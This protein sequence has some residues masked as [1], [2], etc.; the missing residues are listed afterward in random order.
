MEIAELQPQF[1]AQLQRLINDHLALVVDGWA[2]PAEA[3][4]QRL[5]ANPAQHILDPWVRQRA[6]VAAT[7]GG[8]L[9]AA[10]HLLRYGE[11][12]AVGEDYRKAMDIAWLVAEPDEP[13]AADALLE[14]AG[15][16]GRRWGAAAVFA[17]DAGLAVPM[18]GG[19]PDA[20]THIGLALERAGFEHTAGRIERIYGGTLAGITGEGRPAIAGLALE[21]RT[22]PDGFVLQAIVGRAAA[23]HCECVADLTERGA[24]PALRG[25]GEL[26]ELEVEEGWRNRG[27]G[28][29]LIQQALRRLRLAGCERLIFS[30]DSE[31]EARGAGRFYRRFGWEVLARHRVGWQRT[32]V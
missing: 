4:G 31:D 15:E 16:Y 7:E 29:W 5:Q 30:V 1:L 24:L 22:Q 3:I 26:A 11:E 17:L 20:W 28:T 13:E 25:W 27:I 9:L 2:I 12:E 8:R 23:G 6:T 18:V 10:A 19:L 21:E 32:R 14:A